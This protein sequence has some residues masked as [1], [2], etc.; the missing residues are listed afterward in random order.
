MPHA[1]A[2]NYVHVVF[3]TRGRRKLIR[4][5]V[6]EQLHAYIRGIARNYKLDLLAIGG[7]EDHLLL[8]LTL[9]PKLALADAVRAVKANS[10]KW[11][12]ENGRRFSWQQGYAAF[13]VSRSN[14]ESV[15]EYVRTQKEHHARY[16]FED[17]ICALLEKHGIVFNPALHLN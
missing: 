8:L 10:S 4:T 12:N 1:F 13:S 14:L 17:E 16:T 2:L 7:M 15:K 6:E 11:M 5:E 3:S 9:P